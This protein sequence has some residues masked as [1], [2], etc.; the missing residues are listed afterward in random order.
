MYVCSL[1]QQNRSSESEEEEEEE[2]AH[3]SLMRAIRPKRA[4]S[5][6]KLKRRSH[7]LMEG[8]RGLGDADF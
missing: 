6:Y 3:E 8:F 1:T 5:E 7:G 4:Q 2:D